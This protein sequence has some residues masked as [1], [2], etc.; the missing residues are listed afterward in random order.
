MGEADGQGCLSTGDFMYFFFSFP[1]CAADS[2]CD[3]V[4]VF[5]SFFSSCICAVCLSCFLGRGVCLT[6]CTSSR[7]DSHLRF[8]GTTF[9]INNNHGSER[10]KRK[11]Q[12]P[13]KIEQQCSAV[14]V[15]QG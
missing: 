4:D 9:V 3:L 2:L 8:L 13:G 14:L 12:F 5:K 6:V 11:Q 7:F 15:I 10:P 1:V